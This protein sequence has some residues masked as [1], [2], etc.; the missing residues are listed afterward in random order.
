MLQKAADLDLGDWFRYAIG[1]LG[2]PCP[3][4]AYNG[5]L[6]Y[7]PTS[8]D[9]VAFSIYRVPTL[10]HT[11]NGRARN[12]SQWTS[13]RLSQS[14]TGIWNHTFSRMVRKLDLHESATV[15]TI[16]GSRDNKL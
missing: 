5:R 8:R 1:S 13:D 2:S 12:L 15:S 10:A 16:A 6:D 9:L 11:I 14:W 4:S 7:H 3:R